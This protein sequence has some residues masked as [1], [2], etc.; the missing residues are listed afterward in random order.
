NA[1]AGAPVQALTSFDCTANKLITQR[2]SGA[3]LAFPAKL[4]WQ[5]AATGCR[6]IVRHV[7]CGPRGAGGRRGDLLPR[8]LDASG[9]LEGDSPHCIPLTSSSLQFI[10]AVAIT[11]NGRGP[12]SR[13]NGSRGTARHI[14][15]VLRRAPQHRADAC[16]S[17]CFRCFAH[18]R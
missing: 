1:G 5:G 4:P 18:G 6:P 17:L 3:L 7:P 16:V 12:I 15:G 11:A 2:F 10:L 9:T 8:S 13:L 14:L